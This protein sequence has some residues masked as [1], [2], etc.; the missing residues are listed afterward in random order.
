MKKYVVGGYVRDLLRNKHPNDK[1]F[2]V[3]GSSIQEMLSLG[4]HQ[5]GK[6]F[7]VFLHPETKEEYALAR[8]EKKTGNKHTDFIFNFSPTVSLYDDALRRDFTCNALA[9]DEETGEIIDYFQGYQDIKNKI[10]R[11]IDEKNFQT[12]PLRVLR[13]YRFS[14]VLNFK[15]D[16]KTKKILK[17]MVTREMLKFLTPQRVWQEIQKALA[18]G[19]DSAV[20]F[21]GLAKIDGLKDW[22]PE[23]NQ[24]NAIL[25][26]SPPHTFKNKFKTAMRFLT[27]A[28]NTS[29]LVK[30]AILIHN[31]DKKEPTFIDRLCNRLKVPNKYRDFALIFFNNYK[32]IRK[33]EK[34][35]FPQ[36]YDFVKK[37]SDNY[38]NKEKLESFLQGCYVIYHNNKPQNN[39]NKITTDIKKIYTIMNGITLKDLPQKQQEYL[40]KK[41]G[42]EFGKTYR[43]YMI[44]YLKSKL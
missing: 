14:A 13:A 28:K 23:L 6:N 26:P 37:I 41:N 44:R 40:K 11:V 36:K 35:S 1:D 18:P 42:S 9:L 3:V 17:K 16:S 25:P 5:V 19:A 34:M 43:N 8:T 29:D 15:I 7:P 10:I 39:I 20:F 30:W 31:I 38:K 27:Q 33:F 2:V 22:L 12:D 24:I 4:F 32:M 21:E